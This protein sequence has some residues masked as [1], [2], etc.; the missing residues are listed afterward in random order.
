MRRI[1]ESEFEQLYGAT[2]GR[3]YVFATINQ[4]NTSDTLSAASIF[5]SIRSGPVP[6]S[7]YFSTK[8]K[9]SYILLNG[10]IEIILDEDSLYCGD[11]VHIKCSNNQRADNL[12]KDETYVFLID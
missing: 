11:I 10:V 7:I 1:S 4:Q 9:R 5:D 2:E 6:H 3:K 12:R 8:D